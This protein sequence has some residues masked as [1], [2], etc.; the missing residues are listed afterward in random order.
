VPFAP[1]VRGARDPRARG[2]GLNYS[3]R[4]AL[5]ILYGVLAVGVSF[6]CSLLEASL[7]SLPR[8]YVESL[9]HHGSGVGRR[10]KRMKDKID[11]PLA[12]I[13]TLN[14]V[15]HTLGAAG[16]ARRRRR[17]SG[18]KAVGIAS[19]VM[20]L[21]VLVFS[22]IIPKT[23]GAVHAKPLAGFTA[24]T[25]RVLIVLCLPLIVPLEW[26]NRLLVIVGPRG[27]V[28]QPGGAGRDDPPGGSRAGRCVTASTA[29]R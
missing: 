27:S 12:A 1:E 25:V 20:T 24:V 14:T 26:I 4:M 23:L 22:E 18:T 15:A 19:G 17:S 6:L 7:L 10:L 16:W 21:L 11:R 28:D 13:L 3:G 9:A 2:G 8:S 5:L 29:W